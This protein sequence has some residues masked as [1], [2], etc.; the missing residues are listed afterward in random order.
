MGLDM[1]AYAVDENGEEESLAD[2]RKH[3]RL[4]GFMEDLWESKGK[5]YDE[6]L[7]D[8]D[9]NGMGT[10]NCVPVELEVGDLEDLFECI[11]NKTMPETGGFFFGD[12]SFSWEDDDG[13]KPKEGDYYYREKDL[14][15]VIDACKAIKQGK[16]VYYNSWW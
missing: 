12:D 8:L 16:K 1:Y 15:F 14:Q 2:W 11:T 3:N 7:D 6:D 5:P 13:N 10:F 9:S 4:H